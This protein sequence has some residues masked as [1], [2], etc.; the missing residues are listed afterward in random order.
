MEIIFLPLNIFPRTCFC[1]YVLF[2]LPLSQYY[3]TRARDSSL[4]LC[5]GLSLN[6][7]RYNGAETEIEHF[8]VLGSIT[9]PQASTFIYVNVSL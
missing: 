9:F 4:F 5:Y 6:S 8:K 3:Q 2:R 7:H 1:C